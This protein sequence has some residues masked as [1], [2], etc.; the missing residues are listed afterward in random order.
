MAQS[1]GEMLEIETRTYG[2]P[3]FAPGDTM[4]NL[5][6]EAAEAF[7]DFTA[8]VGGALGELAGP[9]GFAIGEELGRK[10]GTW[11]SN[12]I[13]DQLPKAQHTK[14]PVRYKRPFDPVA[15]FDSR[16]RGGLPFN[17][18]QHSSSGL[19]LKSNEDVD[20]CVCTM[21]TLFAN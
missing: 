9:E 15:G 20:P 10:F 5:A 7:S 11:S 14:Y 21:K 19:G 12:R 16:A 2:S 4:K 18:N 13:L 8:G 6:R 3:S 17:L 1:L